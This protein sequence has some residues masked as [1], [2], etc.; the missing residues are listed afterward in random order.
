MKSRI[1][2]NV[3]VSGGFSSEMRLG[4]D[5]KMYSVASSN[6]NKDGDF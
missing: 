5:W 6:G 1:E 3:L 4:L 2:Q